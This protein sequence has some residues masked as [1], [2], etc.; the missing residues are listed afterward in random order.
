MIC[1]VSHCYRSL[2][3]I[4]GLYIEVVQ[5]YFICAFFVQLI[6]AEQRG[7]LYSIANQAWN[8]VVCGKNAQMKYRPCNVI[9]SLFLRVITSGIYIRQNVCKIPYFI[10]PRAILPDM[11]ARGNERLQ[12]KSYIYVI[13]TLTHSSLL[14]DRSLCVGPNEL[15]RFLIKMSADVLLCVALLSLR[16]A[17]CAHISIASNCKKITIM[18]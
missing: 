11:F 1:E 6:C 12:P 13:Y 8:F 15:H 14:S 17:N 10:N 5:C 16:H 2:Y 3:A 18:L 4:C 9:T 7:S